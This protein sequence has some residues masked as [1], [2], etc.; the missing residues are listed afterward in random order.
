MGKNMRSISDLASVHCSSEEPLSLKAMRSQS[1]E[2][3]QNDQQS[4]NLQL[5]SRPNSYEE[6]D[7]FSFFRAASSRCPFLRF[8]SQFLFMAD[9]ES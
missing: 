6:N 3:Q 8:W 9:P 5:K 7:M 2:D 1:R 4:L